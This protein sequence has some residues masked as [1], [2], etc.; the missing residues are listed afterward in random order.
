MKRDIHLAAWYYMKPKDHVFT[1]KS[2][3]TKDPA[4][5]R[6]DEKMELFQGM[7]QSAA[8]NAKVILNLSQA[9][10]VKN[11]WRSGASFE[12]LFEYYLSN[13][14]E[15]ITTG[16]VTLDPDTFKSVL[17]RMGKL[18]LPTENQIPSGTISS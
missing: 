12:E 18:S 17:E 8:K 3:W 14:R 9:K 7:R 5:I 1:S 15:N 13:Y 16:L 6:Y 2:G 11:S 4:N 10:V